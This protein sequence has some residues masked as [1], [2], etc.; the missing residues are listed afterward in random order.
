MGKRTIKTWHV[1]VRVEQGPQGNALERIL[2][3]SSAKSA[4]ATARR[5]VKRLGHRVLGEVTPVR[6]RKAAPQ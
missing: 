4:E 1:V 5:D 2:R 3:A 6:V